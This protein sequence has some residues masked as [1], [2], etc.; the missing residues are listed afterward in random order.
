MTEIRK[1]VEAGAETVPVSAP[2]PSLPAGEAATLAP[3]GTGA[4]EARPTVPGFELL[5]ELGRGGM[6]V[7]FKA[8]QVSLNRFVALKM[9]LAGPY[10][11]AEQ[12]ARFRREAEAVAGLQHPNIVQIYEIGSHAGHAYLALE[13]V[14]GGNLTRKCAGR[15][16]PPD[17]TA[18]LVETL[19][20]AVHYAHQRGIIHR[21]LK[22][23]NVLLTE[24]GEPK[25]TDFGLAMRLAPASP[26]PASPD[27]ASPGRQPGEGLTAS[28]AILGTP[29]Y[30]APEQAGGK[31]G[32]V[33]P[34]ADVYALGAILYELLTGRPPF[35]AANPVA[36]IFKVMTEEPIPPSRVEPTVPRDLETVCL[37]CLQKDPER[38][39]PSAEFL[40]DDLDRFLHGEA[41]QAR[42][43]SGGER[44]RR[45][46]WRRRWWLAGGG[47]AAL[48]L[49]A[50]TCSLGLNLA[51]MFFMPGTVYTSPSVV[52]VS[53]GKS[54]EPVERAVLPDDLALVPRD[55][56]LFLTVRVADLWQHKEM[57]GLN[58]FLVQEK[59]ADLAAL[60]DQTVPIPLRDWERATYVNLQLPVDGSFVVILAT[61]QPYQRD[62]VQGLLAKWGMKVEQLEGKPCFG[63]GPDGRHFVC[64]Y[65]DRILVWS[66]LEQSLRDW[67]ARVPVADAPGT[68]RPALDLAAKERHHFVLGAAPP[69]EVRDGLLRSLPALARGAPAQGGP[70]QPDARSLGEVQTAILT[71]DFRS[72][73]PGGA[74]A[75]LDVDLRF[76]FADPGEAGEGQ[77]ALVSVRDFLA[78]VMKIHATGTVEGFPP[79]L[80]QNLTLTFQNATVRQR[81]SEDRVTLK[82]NALPG[83]LPAAAALFKEEGE[84]VG[85]L[86]N[87]KQ[88]AL[89]IISY[90]DA[91]GGRLPPAAL[92]DKTGKPLLS[93]RVAVLPFLNQGPL[94]TQFKL[95]EPWDSVHNKALLAKMP[96]LFDPPL[97]PKGWQ[98]NTTFYQVFAGDQTLFPPGKTLRYPADIFDGTSNT[99][100]VVEAG[101]AVP[102]TKPVDLPYDPAGPLPML[103]GI[104]HDGFQAVMADG[105]STRFLPKKTPPATLRALITPAGGEVVPLP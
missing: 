41:T 97:K 30:M 26:D 33:G 43:P 14:G 73:N 4:A 5:E 8:R 99:V 47:V 11:G 55:A 40:A 78:A 77:K 57:Q 15:P 6:G 71:A 37:K 12:L 32:S 28:G 96:A 3:P 35:E 63:P 21:D 92:T 48:L 62:R 23:G 90:A 104:F 100:M 25:I 24:D 52:T 80:A 70:K 38:R 85:S 79:S 29:A 76:G 94:Y 16:L 67:L 46:A 19:A 103:G 13:Y 2:S 98:P 61:A 86:N 89:G 83:W 69:R 22:P 18:D 101:E 66:N 51:A 88:L 42:P 7:V 84:R 1:D 72:G 39:Y 10:A 49:L 74:S 17:Q 54:A 95:D 53:E 59:I 56:P 91:H 31:R 75:G 93:W 20:R 34:A 81:G 87:L 82:M 45:W 44:F 9:I 102:W 68:L 64:L 105:Q 58:E 36:V 27:L 50:L 65:S 60:A